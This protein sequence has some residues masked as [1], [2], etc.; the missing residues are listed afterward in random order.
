V[1]SAGPGGHRLLRDVGE[2]GVIR[3]VLTRYTRYGA[4]PAFLLVG[5]G[6]DAAVLEVSDRVVVSTD[7]VVEGIDFRREWS[8]GADVGVKVAAQSF[9]DVAAMGARPLALVVSLAAPPD[10]PLAWA[11]DL[12]AGLDDECVRA[13]AVVAGGDMA[14]ARQVVV[15]GTALGVLAGPPVLRSGARPGD[16]VALAGEVGASAAGLALLTAAG[17][18]RA[19]IA[20][21]LS[22]SALVPAHLAP[23]PFYDAGIE[24]AHGGATALIDTSD[25]LLRDA[26]RVAAASGVRID[27]D[28]GP[29]SPDAGLISA[30]R[31]VGDPSLAEL[32]VLTGGEDHA[33]LGC[34]PVDHPL[35]PAFRPVGRVLQAEDGGGDVL[36]GG[37]PWT[38][39]PG[40]QHF[41]GG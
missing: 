18:P 5:P 8:S 22:A 9:A 31:A 13:G 30:A 15:T 25:G 34:F 17:S 38:G 12:A 3:T 32:W 39:S 40:W 1:T 2:D 28:L 41:T 4:S 19:A 33:L 6:D 11:D 26:A 10:L 37:R 14:Q 29:L 24:A 16:V 20:L 27:L 36:V 21:T 35:P 7:T 23:R